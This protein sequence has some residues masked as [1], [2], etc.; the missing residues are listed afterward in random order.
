MHCSDRFHGL[1]ALVPG[2]STPSLPAADNV[3]GSQRAPT[4]PHSI[5]SPS[6]LPTAVL[7]ISQGRIIDD[8]QDLVPDVPKSHRDVP[9]M[10][11]YSQPT[12]LIILCCV[13]FVLPLRSL[14]FPS[15]RVAS[16]T[17]SRTLFLMSPSSTAM[18]SSW[19]R[20]RW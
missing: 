19:P 4:R 8:V 5:L 20:T 14:L 2:T 16:L 17:M 10:A 15:P 18:F 1:Y 11:M 3:S 13:N 9:F 7:S 6:F 12:M